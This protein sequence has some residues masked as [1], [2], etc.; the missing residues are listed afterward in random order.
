[1]WQ[2]TANQVVIRQYWNAPSRPYGEEGIPTLL[3]QNVFAADNNSYTNQTATVRPRWVMANW[4]DTEEKFDNVVVAMSAKYFGGK[5]VLLAAQR[6][7]RFSSQLRSRMEY[8]D[9]PVSWDGVTLLYKPVAPD[10]W[11]TLSY[12]PRNVTTGVALATKSV[13]AATRPREN[14][15]GVVTNNGVQ[16]YNP[17]FANDRFRNDYRR[18]PT[19]SSSTTISPDRGRVSVTTAGCASGSS[20]I[21]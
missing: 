5:L 18:P 21:G 3:S 6:Y 14:A 20:A 19:P 17:F 9:L 13:P 11:A 8:G 15:P 1:M 4:D 12:I 7:D 2:S 16:I 10:D